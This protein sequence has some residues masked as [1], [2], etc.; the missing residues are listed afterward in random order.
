[1]RLSMS[2]KNSILTVAVAG[3]SL[4][5]ISPEAQGQQLLLATD[6]YFFSPPQFLSPFRSNLSR[7]EPAHPLLGARRGSKE[8]QTWQPAT[9]RPAIPFSCAFATRNGSELSPKPGRAG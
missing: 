3:L 6:T 1:M 4:L 8:L 7:S 9:A 5:L 2:L